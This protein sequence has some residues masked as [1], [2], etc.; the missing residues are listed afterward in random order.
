MRDGVDQSVQSTSDGVIVV[1]LHSFSFPKIAQHHHQHLQRNKAFSSIWDDKGRLS[2]P[3]FFS[4]SFHWIPCFC[5]INRRT[6]PYSLDVTST[7][8]KVKTGSPSESKN[9][10]SKSTPASYI[11]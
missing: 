7:V 10:L 11:L 5:P 8:H 3:L 9:V 4:F 1:S 6:L 2:N